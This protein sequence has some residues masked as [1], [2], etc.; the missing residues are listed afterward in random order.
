LQGVAENEKRLLGKVSGARISHDSIEG[1]KV[2]NIPKTSNSHSRE[3]T[4]LQVGE[5]QALQGGQERIL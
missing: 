5:R 3:G 1:Q 4:Q 2:T